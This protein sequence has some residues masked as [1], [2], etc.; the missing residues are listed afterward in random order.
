VLAVSL[1]LVGGLLVL[2]ERRDAPELEGRPTSSANTTI[3]S[4]AL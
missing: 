1:A 2:H 3:R 4:R